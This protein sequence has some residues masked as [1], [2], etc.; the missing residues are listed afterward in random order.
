MSSTERLFEVDRNL[1]EQEPVIDTGMV[2]ETGTE[3]TTEPTVEP[4]ETSISELFTQSVSESVASVA[5]VFENKNIGVIDKEPIAG[6][7]KSFALR[8]F[9]RATVDK[10]VKPADADD[11]IDLME[12]FAMKPERV[13]EENAEL[14]TRVKEQTALEEI[15]MGLVSVIKQD[16]INDLQRE[17]QQKITVYDEANTVT[18]DEFVRIQ[19]WSYFPVVGSTL[20]FLMLL[21]IVFDHSAK[22][23][24]SL[25]N[26][27]KAQLKFFWIY[28]VVTAVTV[29]TCCAAGISFINI[30]Q[31]GLR[32]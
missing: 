27:A 12:L 15:D 17:F 30:I 11:D 6:R 24:A 9:Q 7:F 28:L 13:E 32:A 5:S 10:I 16:V 14:I 4:A 2:A 8:N 23:N 21:A 22:Y 25:K 1:E 3:P 26:W 29:F 31:R 18:T 19:M 20:Y